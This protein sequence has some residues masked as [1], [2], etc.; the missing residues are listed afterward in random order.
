MPRR[1]LIPIALISSLSLGPLI[2]CES[3]P[4]GK[5]EQGAVI[6]GVGGAAAGAVVGGEEHRLLGALLGGA[7]GAG[8]GYLIG[9]QMSKNDAQHRDEA[10]QASRRAEQTP[11]RPQDVRNAT[12]AD[13]NNDGFVTLDEVVAMRQAGLGDDEMIRRLRATGQIFELTTQQEDYLRNHNVDDR[14]IVAMRNMNQP[15]GTPR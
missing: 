9:A 15:V 14:I 4:G 2:S 12:T 3:L 5:K 7:L 13:L 11:A 1:K 8:G 6:G 10:V